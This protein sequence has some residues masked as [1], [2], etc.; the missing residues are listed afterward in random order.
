MIQT[1][2]IELTDR[3]GEP[4]SVHITTFPGSKGV[5]LFSRVF[6]LIVPVV[7]PALNSDDKK[8]LQNIDVDFSQI[9]KTIA[10]SMNDKKIVALI[11]DLVSMTEVILKGEKYQLNS[12]SRFD[13]LFAGNYALLLQTI[14][15]VLEVN[16]ADFFGENGIKDLM[17][18]IPGITLKQ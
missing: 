8:S 5:E 13:M 10:V 14:K 18:Q 17:T 4:V 12:K 9:A 1:K 11:H 6:L 7:L 16:F 15:N 2:E 3:D